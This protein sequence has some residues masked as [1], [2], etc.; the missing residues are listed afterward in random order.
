MSQSDAL[1]FKK[2]HTSIY[3]VGLRKK[4]RRYSFFVVFRAD[5][6]CMMLIEAG[7]TS[8]SQSDALSFKKKGT[9]NWKRDATQSNLYKQRVWCIFGLPAWLGTRSLVP[10]QTQRLVRIRPGKFGS[11]EGTP[12]KE[13]NELT[14]ER[15]DE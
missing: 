5:Y 3:T 1:S 9:S 12:K 2:I 11:A 15:I 13:K 8:V 7:S 4:Q 6:V 14:E 10:T